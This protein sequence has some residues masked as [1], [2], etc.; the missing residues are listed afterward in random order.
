MNTGGILIVILVICFSFMIITQLVF[1]RNRKKARKNIITD[2]HN[3]IKAE[4]SNNIALI[5]K[6]G[7]R[8]I[9]NRYVS[10]EKIDKLNDSLSSRLIE[11][12]ELSSLYDLTKKR[13]SYLSDEEKEKIYGKS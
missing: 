4:N 10:Q 5:I 11:Y 3:F 9:W 2:W 7:E 6:Y 8:L 1:S 13:R 12:P